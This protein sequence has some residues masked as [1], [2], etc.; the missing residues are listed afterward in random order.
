M[1]SWN[2]NAKVKLADNPDVIVRPV[3]FLEF[4]ERDELYKYITTAGA[5]HDTVCR[6]LMKMLL[7]AIRYLNSEG[8]AHRDLKPE[9]I[10]F[11]LN[12]TLKVAD[13][14]LSSLM[15]GN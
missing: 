4:A 3:I 9:N 12:Y 7:E 11:D 6:R 5:F 13:F 14:G 8:I 1:V 2:A 10:L 15:S